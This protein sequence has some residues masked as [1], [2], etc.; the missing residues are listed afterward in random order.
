MGLADPVIAH[1]PPVTNFYEPGHIKFN[2]DYTLS[3][4]PDLIVLEISP[5]RDM[6]L[7]MTRTKYER[8][9]YHLEYLVDTHRTPRP[10]RILPVRGL[11]ELVITGLIEDGYDYA[12]AARNDVPSVE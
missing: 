12:V 8:G 9:G 10:R 3:R 2:S 4:H 6:G 5:N 1:M 7:G 11:S